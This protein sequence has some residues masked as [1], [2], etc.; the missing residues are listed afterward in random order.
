LVEADGRSA[1]VSAAI[2]R[3]DARVKL[4]GAPA[5]ALIVVGYLTALGAGVVVAHLLPSQPLWLRGAAADAIA[6]VVIFVFSL[7]T[8]CSSFYDPYWSVAPIPIVAWLAV[9]PG[10]EA[11]PIARR[12]LAVALIS[13]WGLRLTWNWA[14]G[15][16]GFAAEDWR[17]VSLRR[18]TGRS[19]W[20][21]SLLGL[22]LMPTV[23]VYLALLP[24]FA[25]LGHAAP[26]V[27]AAAPAPFG[28]L[29]VVAAIVT[30]AAL[31]VEATADEQLRAFR[32]ENRVSGAIC[33]RGLWGRCR[34][35]NYLG[36]IGIW[37]GAFAFGLAGRP[38]AW[39]AYAVGAVWMTMLFTL[40]SIPMIDKR[41]LA[42]RPGYAD[43][44]RRMPALLPLGPRGR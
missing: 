36:E 32:R 34:H 8:D 24:I 43:H 42:R 17:Y 41:S 4:R 39:W 30:A 33:T 6:T 2:E 20:L 12:A 44:M 14:R 38:D 5:F 27:E 28:A 26:L 37:W 40:I 22:H 11:A 31:V 13:A 23:T 3:D 15:W 35:P 18:T 9:A 19:Y 25:A 1:S 21:V 16:T 29:D 10:A 7:F